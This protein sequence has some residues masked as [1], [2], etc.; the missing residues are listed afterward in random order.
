MNIFYT[1]AIRE[2]SPNT[3][4]LAICGEKICFK[5]CEVCEILL[6]DIV[7]KNKAYKSV[8]NNVSLSNLKDG[9]NK[10]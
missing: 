7:K 2:I 9:E 3:S 6:N 10:R 8:P 5:D 4:G 1:K